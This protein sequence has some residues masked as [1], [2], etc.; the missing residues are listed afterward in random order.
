[1]NGAD[2]YSILTN[3]AP[4]RRLLPRPPCATLSA[5]L[6]GSFPAQSLTDPEEQHCVGFCSA[7]CPDSQK[8]QRGLGEQQDQNRGGGEEPSRQPQLLNGSRAPL[9]EDGDRPEGT[10]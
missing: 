7:V 3:T 9:S 2:S 8:G 10:A 4:T 6:P 1:M 5:E